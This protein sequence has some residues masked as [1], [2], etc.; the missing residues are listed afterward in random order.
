MNI[1][2]YSSFPPNLTDRD[3]LLMM[4]EAKIQYRCCDCE[5]IGTIDI[6][7]TRNTTVFKCDK[8]HVEQHYPMCNEQEI[9][10]P[11]NAI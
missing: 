4:Y 5:H 9:V 11:R 7:G 6:S 8:C 2:K 3:I 1:E 10:K